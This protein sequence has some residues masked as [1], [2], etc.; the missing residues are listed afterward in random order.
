MP[1]VTVTIPREYGYVLI[2][3]SSTFFLSTWHAVRVG[4]FRKRAGI[5]YPQRYATPEQEAAARS[6]DPAR[7]KAMYLFN[8][9]QRAHGN[10]LESYPSALAGLL[11]AGLRFP[12]AAAAT[13][14]LWSVFRTLY[15]VGY[16]RA[17]REGGKGRLV[18]SGFWLCQGAL[19]VM[20]GWAG[21]GLLME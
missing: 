17:D 6:A 16:T 12:V 19:Y 8:C 1:D 13:A 15:A 20:A 7:A 11:L 10:F 18:G 21:V 5:P 2:V 9:A 4:P 3:A 14:A